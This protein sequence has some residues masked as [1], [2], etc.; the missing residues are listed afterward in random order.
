MEISWKFWPQNLM[1]IYI[2]RFSRI[3]NT[4]IL[5]ILLLLSKLTLYLKVGFIYLIHTHTHTTH[6]Y[7]HTHTQG[8]RK[9]G[10]CVVS[11]RVR[12]RNW[13]VEYSSMSIYHISFHENPMLPRCIAGWKGVA[14]LEHRRQRKLKTYTYLWET[15]T[16][17]VVVLCWNRFRT[18][19][20]WARCIFLSSFS[21]RYPSIHNVTSFSYHIRYVW[22]WTWTVCH[23]KKKKNQHTTTIFRET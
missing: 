16:S 11:N 8:K 22:T 2:Y 23:K 21:F 14:L 10:W 5:R 15:Q 4:N 9:L 19:F 7:T 12:T 20:S 13:W 17:G 1:K 18:I 6:I 3:K